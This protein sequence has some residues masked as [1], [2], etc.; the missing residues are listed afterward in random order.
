MGRT[1]F[2]W[3]AVFC[4]AIG[5]VYARPAA[6]DNS[7]VCLAPGAAVQTPTPL[8]FFPV[9]GGM[10]IKRAHACPELFVVLYV[11]P[12]PTTLPL[13]TSFGSLTY[14]SAQARRARAASY[15][16]AP[17]PE[18]EVYKVAP[19]TVFFPRPAPARSRVRPTAL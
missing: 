12:V 5:L 17:V 6:A 9:V 4:V 3:R 15:I 2:M 14:G 1:K 11:Q 8:A 19:K 7:I 10:A 18:V 16:P 13:T